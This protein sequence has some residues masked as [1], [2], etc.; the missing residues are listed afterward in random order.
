MIECVIFFGVP[1]LSH[2]RKQLYQLYVC[3]WTLFAWNGETANSYTFIC[4]TL[5]WFMFL[6]NVYSFVF[7]LFSFSK[8]PISNSSL[9]TLCVNLWIIDSVEIE[10]I[11]IFPCSFDYAFK[12]NLLIKSERSE[13]IGKV[14]VDYDGDW[15]KQ[16]SMRCKQFRWV[17]GI[18]EAFWHWMCLVA[19][20][21]RNLN[22]YVNVLVCRRK[23]SENGGP[24][25]IIIQCWQFKHISRTVYA[26]S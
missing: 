18:L 21:L 5:T 6:V 11:S 24:T 7:S 16:Q 2:K 15:N 19:N 14:T 25:A 4:I 22:K 17:N 1:S 23:H 8:H 3:A 26:V 13:Q 9:T 12:Q 20:I 10:L